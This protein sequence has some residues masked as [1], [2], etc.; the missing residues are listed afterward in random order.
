MYFQRENSNTRAT[1]RWSSGS[2]ITPKAVLISVGH[3]DVMNSTKIVAVGAE[4][5]AASPIRNHASGEAVPR[6]APAAP[7]VSAMPATVRH[8][9]VRVLVLPCALP[10][11]RLFPSLVGRSPLSR[12]ACSSSASPPDPWG[13]T[14]PRPAAP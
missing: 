10:L 13:R 8:P 1:L 14:S 7:L 3:S 11:V 5:H 12:S 6:S 4:L 2:D 9:V